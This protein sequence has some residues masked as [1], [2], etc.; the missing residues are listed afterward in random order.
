MYVLPKNVANI[1]YLSP[2]ESLTG[3]QNLTLNKLYNYT[4]GINDLEDG[5]YYGLKIHNVI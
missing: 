4:H 2:L 5:K 3:V 1:E